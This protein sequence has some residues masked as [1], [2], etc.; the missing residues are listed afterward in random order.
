MPLTCPKCGVP[1]QAHTDILDCADALIAY[2]A[3][4]TV[5][6]KQATLYWHDEQGKPDFDRPI[7]EVRIDNLGRLSINMIH[8]NAPLVQFDSLE[9]LGYALMWECRL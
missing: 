7:A 3:E 9:Q 5:M 1:G 2:Y 4:D 8:N 6:L